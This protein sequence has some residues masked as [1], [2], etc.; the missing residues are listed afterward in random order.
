ML[1]EDYALTEKLGQLDREMCDASMPMPAILSW[2]TISIC[3]HLFDQMLIVL[4]WIVLR[5]LAGGLH[6]MKWLQYVNRGRSMRITI[7]HQVCSRKHAVDCTLN[8][9][10]VTATESRV[11]QYS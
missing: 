6:R 10:G 5:E 7:E 8:P 3:M 11:W 2:K 4:S 9:A 1:L